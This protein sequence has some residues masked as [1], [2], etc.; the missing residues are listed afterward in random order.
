MDAT[1]ITA[2]ALALAL[3]AVVLLLIHLNRRAVKYR[4]METFPAF[5]SGIQRENFFGQESPT[6]TSPASPSPAANP[7]VKE[8]V[9]EEAPEEA[10]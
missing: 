1:L 8:Y 10:H 6:E 5:E 9:V 2:G 3:L 7:R 4:E